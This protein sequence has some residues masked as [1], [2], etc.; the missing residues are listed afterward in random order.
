M[1]INIIKNIIKIA[2]TNAKKILISI[3]S[4]DLFKKNIF[5]FKIKNDNFFQ[6]YLH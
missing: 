3:L 1:N 6:N 4:I 2:A 5:I